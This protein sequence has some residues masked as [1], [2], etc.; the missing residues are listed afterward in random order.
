[1]PYLGGVSSSSITNV[2]YLSWLTSNVLPLIPGTI[3]QNKF[4]LFIVSY[5]PQRIIFI[6]VSETKISPN[7]F[8]V[9]G[10]ESHKSIKGCGN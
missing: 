7:T 10:N 4:L 5:F 9:I 8:S 2:R 6:D 1:M 3:N